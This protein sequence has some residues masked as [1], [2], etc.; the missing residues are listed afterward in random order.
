MIR[1]RSIGCSQYPPCLVAAQQ[2]LGH[3]LLRTVE[4]Q[5]EVAVV[6]RRGLPRVPIAG[7]PVD[8]ESKA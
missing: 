7:S 6:P 4:E 5:H 3:D 1:S 2:A 8:I